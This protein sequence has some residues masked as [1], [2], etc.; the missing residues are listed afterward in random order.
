MSKYKKI[1][2]GFIVL[3][4]FTACHQKNKK[5]ENPYN[6]LTEKTLPLVINCEEV[7][8]DSH[9]ILSNELLTQIF[10]L[11]KKQE[12]YPPTIATTLPSEWLV[13][14]QIENLSSNFD[15]WVISNTNEITHKVLL[16]VEKTETSY[17]IIAALTVAYS[18]AMEKKDSLASE[19]WT[20]SIEK[21]YTIKVKKKYEKIYSS[22]VDSIIPVNQLIETEDIYHI[23][24]NG[25]I[26]YEQPIKFD[27]DY[28]AIIQFA[29]TSE[30]GV[31]IDEDWL[32]NRIRMQETLEEYNILFVET[33]KN[34]DKIPI[35]NYYG[36]EVD[37]V[38]ITSFLTTH[39]KGYIF[40]KKGSKPYYYR[41]CP[42]EECIKKALPYFNITQDS[43]E[44]VMEND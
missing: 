36:E 41:Y 43:S 29:D 14:Y 21:D 37:I 39:S 40:L 1:I 27:T 25:M 16:T 31:E 44:V 9:P 6:N 35:L 28:M 12:G 20:C 24:L 4:I 3:G 33:S 10:S 18:V 7:Y 11:L 8:G 19:E 15:I 22:V 34:F 5:E 2:F 30:V 42:A 13:E 26:T 23:S 38:S 17:R 32:W